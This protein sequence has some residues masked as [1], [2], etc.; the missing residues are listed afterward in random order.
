ML[1]SQGLPVAAVS[2]PAPPT[3]TQAMAWADLGLQRILPTLAPEHGP[4]S[5]RQSTAASPIRV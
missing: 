5:N 1:I 4:G 2:K 3:E